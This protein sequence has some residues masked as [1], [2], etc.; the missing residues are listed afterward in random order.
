MSHLLQRNARYE[1]DLLDQLFNSSERRLARTLLLLAHFDA[2]ADGDKTVSGVTQQTLA[3]MVGTTRA[4]I[5]VFMSRFRR[6]G[7]IEYDRATIR[8]H[9][10]LMTKVRND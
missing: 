2:G 9:A 8:V 4:H 3:E 1:E 7:L 10:S 6:M 5:S